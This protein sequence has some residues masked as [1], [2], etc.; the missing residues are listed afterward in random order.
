MERLIKVLI[1]LLAVFLV[2]I[3]VLLGLLGKTREG[4]G[5]YVRGGWLPGGLGVVDNE[6][7]REY[8]GRFL[9]CKDGQMVLVRSRLEEKSEVKRVVFAVGEKETVQKVTRRFAD[10]GSLVKIAYAYED[11]GESLVYYLMPV[12][13][14]D[15]KGGAKKAEKE[16]RLGMVVNQIMVGLSPLDKEQREETMKNWD[17]GGKLLVDMGIKLR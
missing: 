12:A 15:V 9:S 11:G 3:G 17:T 16:R 5:V 10:N 4:C 13:G 6:K 2:I 14:G 1:G 7:W 8:T